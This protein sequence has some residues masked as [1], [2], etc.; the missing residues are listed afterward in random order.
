MYKAILPFVDALTSKR[1]SPGDEFVGEAERIQRL[2]DIRFIEQVT[3]TVEA[4][5]DGSKKK[6]K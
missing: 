5:D 3:P 1:Y 6:A 4:V 2:V